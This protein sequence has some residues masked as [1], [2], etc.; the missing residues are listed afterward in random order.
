MSEALSL[1]WEPFH[2]SLCRETVPLLGL[3]DASRSKESV[4]LSAVYWLPLREDLG[5]YK[6]GN[7]A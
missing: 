5:K 4:L 7:F 1:V 3:G 6:M 2:H